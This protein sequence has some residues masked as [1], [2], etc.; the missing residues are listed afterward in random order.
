MKVII[1]GSGIVGATTAYYLAKNN[2][3]V[4]L[5]DRNE[6]GRATD[7]A[8]GII[9]PWLAQRRNQA[10]Y[11][12]AQKGARFYPELVE[13]LATDGEEDIGYDQVGAIQLHTVEQRL[14]AA[15]ER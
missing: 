5:I 6:P 11:T 2:I 1:I 15:E 4:T 10:W 14:L 13:S 3:H 12:L 9:C 7:A 8:A